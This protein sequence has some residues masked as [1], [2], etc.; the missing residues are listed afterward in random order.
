MLIQTRFRDGIATGAVTLTFRRWKRSQVVT[1]HQ[2]RTAAGRIEVDAVDVIDPARISAADA[3]RAGYPGRAELLAD[4]RGS[5]DLP[6]Y[7]IKFH[8]LDGADP[9]DTLAATGALS[10]DDV[11]ELDH[12]LDRLD[13][14]SAHGPWTRAVLQVIAKRPAVRAADLAHGFGRETQPFKLDVRKLKN[15]G[16]TISLEVGYRLSPRGEAYLASKRGS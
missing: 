15:L 11:A 12:R 3:R 5:S 16:L 7:R 4:L 8:A 1:G 6:T 2:Y 13:R 9:R 10:A 14:A